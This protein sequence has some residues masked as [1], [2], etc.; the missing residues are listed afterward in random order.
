M[1]ISSLGKPRFERCPH[2][3]DGGCAIYATRPEECAAFGC[4]WLASQEMSERMRPDRSGI[5]VWSEPAK[6]GQADANGTAHLTW[7]QETRPRGLEGYWAQK[8]LRQLSRRLL[9]FGIRYGQRVPDRTQIFGP[10]H[11]VAEA[12]RLR[13]E[14]GI[15]I[16]G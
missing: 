13:R 6:F 4:W 1:G 14:G 7:A 11:L 15:G 5:L 10:P 8:M 3:S 12:A 2:L 9:I 16:I